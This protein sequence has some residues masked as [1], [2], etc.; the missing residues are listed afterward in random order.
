MAASEPTRWEDF[1]RRAGNRAR[2]ALRPIYQRLRGGARPHPVLIVGVARSGSTMA[3]DAFERSWHTEVYVQRD[4]RLFEKHLL[5]DDRLAGRLARSRATAIVCKP[6]HENQR[7]PELLRRFPAARVIWLWRDYG[8]TIN[9]SVRKWNTMVGHLG[10]VVADPDEAGWYGA[11][12]TPGAL[13]LAR[14]HY[15]D[16]MSNESAYGLFWT[17]RQ[18]MYFDLDLSR[19]GRVRIVRYED[20]AQRPQAAFREMFEFAECPFDL[21]CIRYVHGSSIHRHARP[22]IDPAIEAVCREM[23]DRLQAAVERQQPL[24]VRR[25]SHD[26]QSHPSDVVVAANRE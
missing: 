15:R 24:A 23:T 8:D 20:L 22:A 19:E 6:M 1:R 14:R 13:D 9:S 3:V 21:D 2:R 17:M 4:A 10:R 7:V 5:Q 26:C 16:E 25:P 12:I 11:G 18:Q